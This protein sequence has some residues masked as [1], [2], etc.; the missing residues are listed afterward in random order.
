MNREN[1][2]QTTA[3][4]VVYLKTFNF[5][6]CRKGLLE[7]ARST[8]VE[9]GEFSSLENAFL[10]GVASSGGNVQDPECVNIFKGNKSSR[11]NL[12]LKNLI[13]Q[14]ESLSITIKN[15]KESVRMGTNVEFYS[16]WIKNVDN[17]AKRFKQKYSIE[18]NELYDH[19]LRLREKMQQRL[20]QHRLRHC[21]Y[22]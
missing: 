11:M 13:K 18:C 2:V 9:I 6:L 15:N 4:L 16:T 17:L 3:K 22:Q 7:R 5:K 20:G 12:E 19:H 21:K 8:G 14:T 1:L 10:R